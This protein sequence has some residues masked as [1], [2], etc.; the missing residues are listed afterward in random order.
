MKFKRL[1]AWG[2]AEG[3]FVLSVLTAVVFAI[4]SGE[5][6]SALKLTEADLGL[7]SGVFF[8]T[9]ALS[10]LLFGMLI[11]K[12]PLR[13]L[14]AGSA[15]LTS[16]G[17]LIF[18]LS[19]GFALALLARTLMGI[20]LSSTFVGVI[21]LLGVDYRESFPFMSTLSQSIANLSAA[22]LSLL[23]ACFFASANFRCLFLTLSLL[24]LLTAIALFLCIGMTNQA[25]SADVTHP[26]S[27]TFRT[28]LSEGQFW[29]AVIF[30][31][32]TFGTMLGFADLWGIQFQLNF[33]HHSLQT[34]AVM[35]AMIPLGVTLG[36][37][38]AGAW[39]LRSGFALPVRVFTL[40]ILAC[41][42]V[43]LI[44]PLSTV[45]SGLVMF[46]IGFGFSCSTLAMT[47]IFQQLPRFTAPLATSLTVTAACLFGGLIQPLVGLLIGS[48]NFA[49]KFLALVQTS[50]PDFR[51]YQRGMICLL[52][53][54]LAALSASCFFRS[55]SARK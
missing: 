52:L 55:D 21:Y 26:L 12:I 10:Q 5:I 31:S 7:L 20:G 54:V 45:T 49:I 1:L 33:F 19:S 6:A 29:A 40:L 39:A 16:L 34:S 25:T 22:A 48:H 51:A 32:G 42:V 3:F 36:G 2:A 13:L 14:L 23:S 38:I 27:A 18:G 47:A 53:S 44:V 4:T 41:F 30:Y 35:N 8:I 17:T 9:Y 37:L 43:L 15:L 46:L 11:S 50:N 28:I 24:F